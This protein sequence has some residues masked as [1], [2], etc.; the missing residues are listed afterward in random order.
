MIGDSDLLKLKPAE[1]ACTFA[2]RD[3]FRDFTQ[4]VVNE[5]LYIHVSLDHV[6]HRPSS[7]LAFGCRPFHGL[8]RWILEYCPETCHGVYWKQGD[9]ARIP[10][11]QY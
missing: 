8:E 11:A 10:L 4:S 2:E 7:A 6:Q 1:I 3:M 9:V 5:Q